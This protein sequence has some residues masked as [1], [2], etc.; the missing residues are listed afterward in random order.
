[1][2]KGFKFYA[3]CRTATAFHLPPVIVIVRLISSIINADEL[4]LLFPFNYI[5]PRLAFNPCNYMYNTQT[6][7]SKAIGLHP[8]PIAGDEDG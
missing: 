5:F 3:L 1:M 7:I 8:P 2:R 4:A 6:Y